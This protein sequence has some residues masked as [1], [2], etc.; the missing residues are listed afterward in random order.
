MNRKHLPRF[1]FLFFYYLV[2][3]HKT[4]FESNRQFSKLNTDEGNLR[5]EQMLCSADVLNVNECAGSSLGNDQ[6]QL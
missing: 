1:F 3:P 2:W 6:L 5:I 4:L